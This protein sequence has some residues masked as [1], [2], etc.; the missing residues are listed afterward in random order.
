MAARGAPG[1]EVSKSA[2]GF[3][4]IDGASL[5][6]AS[7]VGAGI[8][9]VPAFVAGTAGSPVLMLGLWLAGGLLAMGGALCYAE[10]AT[11]FQ[12]GGAEYVYLREAFGETAGF[13]SGWTSFIAGFSGAIAAAAVAFA[14]HL[15]GVFPALGIIATWTA[16]AGPV[17]F[18]LSATTIVAVAIIGLFTLVSVAGIGASRLVT[19][20]LA[21]LIVVGLAV[22]TAAGFLSGDTAVVEKVPAASIGA[23]SALVPIFFTYSGWNAAAYVAGEFRNPG[24]NIPRA[25]IGGALVVT[26]LYVGMNAALIRILSP[27]GLA[28]SSTPVATAAEIVF[29]AAGGALTTMLVLAA[30]ASSV[31]ALVITGPRIYREM[32]RDG[33]LPAMFATSTSRDGSPTVAAI[34]QSVWSAL[35]VLTGTFAQI[36]TYTGF[37]ILVFSGIAVSAVIVL[38]RR[39]GK[40]ATFA[41][42]GYPI[43]PLA[44]I[45]VVV[46]VAIAS[47][48]YAPGPSIV[49]V[50][51]IAAGVP[52]RLV[53][54]QHQHRVTAESAEGLRP[55]RDRERSS[56]IP[57]ELE[58][59]KAR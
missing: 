55:R 45:S 14:A 47:F 49:G 15:T 41:V 16:T 26:L 32:A 24:K 11:R 13:L 35:L 50:L 40:P 9:T 36:V 7:V 43:L 25:L 10:L 51:L 22:M 23:L 2:G 8:F 17:T 28:A 21:L 5:V 46:L 53:T 57:I 44:F 34:A 1:R 20:G 54:R 19:N 30:L 12:R 37:A 29:G 48:R 56:E 39:H 38:R 58:P 27:S 42:P 3:G 33:G 18:T 52:V 4:A 59:G 31:C 6:I